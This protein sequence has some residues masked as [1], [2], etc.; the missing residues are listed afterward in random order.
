MPVFKLI[1]FVSHKTVPTLVVIAF[2]YLVSFI[3]LDLFNLHFI[4]LFH[5]KLSLSSSVSSSK[6]MTRCCLLKDCGFVPQIG[7]EGERADSSLDLSH[8]T[9]DEQI[10]IL[11][12]LQ[13]DFDLRRL[14]EGRV[15]SEV[16]VNPISATFTYGHL[17]TRD[18]DRMIM[19]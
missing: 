19:N 17:T 4:K 10:T 5:F 13:R 2:S 11:E 14:D 7:M 15:R 6:Y 9:E 1:V 16:T 12:V 3:I 8:L 18:C